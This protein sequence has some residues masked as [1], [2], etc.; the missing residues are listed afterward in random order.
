MLLQ[1]FI[2]KAFIEKRGLYGYIATSTV[3]LKQKISAKTKATKSKTV[4]AVVTKT[5]RTKAEKLSKVVFNA[6]LFCQQSL[7]AKS[8]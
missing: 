3:E 8:C 1:K 2:W 6:N 4:K 5:K 7:N